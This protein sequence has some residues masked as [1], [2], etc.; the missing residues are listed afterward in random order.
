MNT[1]EVLKLVITEEMS[2]SLKDLGCTFKVTPGAGHIEFY[3]FGTLLAIP[4]YRLYSNTGL[5]REGLLVLDPNETLEQME[6]R[7][8]EFARM[9]KKLRSE[10]DTVGKPIR[11]IK[12]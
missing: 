9:I 6:F 10:L 5:T 11:R 8:R 2:S 4:V 7:T 3:M 12:S 1:L